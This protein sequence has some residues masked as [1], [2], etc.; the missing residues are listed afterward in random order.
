MHFSAH[1]CCETCSLFG[2]FFSRRCFVA[3]SQRRAEQENIFLFR[4]KERACAPRGP[5]RPAAAAAGAAGD[6]TDGDSRSQQSS[7]CSSATQ[8]SLCKHTAAFPDLLLPQPLLFLLQESSA[9]CSSNL[10]ERE[11]GAGSPAAPSSSL[12]AALSLSLLASR[13]RS[14]SSGDVRAMHV[15]S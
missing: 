11:R 9:S 14:S 4:R 3:A 8:R 2:A 15:L 12:F 13:V 5:K 6:A 10:Q 7:S 1:F